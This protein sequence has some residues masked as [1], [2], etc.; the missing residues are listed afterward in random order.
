MS[1]ACCIPIQ[2]HTLRLCNTHCFSTVAIVARTHACVTFYVLACLV[3]FRL[4]FVCL[5]SFIELCFSVAAAM[6]DRLVGEFVER[7]LKN[8]WTRSWLVSSY[9]PTIFQ[10]QLRKIMKIFMKMAARIE[11]R[12]RNLTSS[13][14]IKAEHYGV[15]ATT[16][17]SRGYAVAQLVE[18]LR[19]K[20]EGR[21]FD[22]RWCHWNFSLT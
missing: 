6:L 5:F 12:A 10:E 4:S 2:I 16:T 1:S 14:N 7:D 20:S 19:Y 15:T 13:T 21:G 18:A 17:T 9:C 11:F 3:I 22:P 8:V